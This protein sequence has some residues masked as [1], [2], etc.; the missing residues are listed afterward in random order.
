MN[1]KGMGYIL[2]DVPR[3]VIDLPKDEGMKNARVAQYLKDIV[4]KSRESR[5]VRLFAIKIIRERHVAPKDYMGEIEA[6]F[7]FVR[8]EI[9]YRKDAA[10]LDTFTEPEQ[11]IKDYL[12]GTPSGDCDDKALLL[13]S[14][15]L[16]LGHVP[17]FV[18][19][20]NMPGGKYTHIYV[21]VKHPKEN[22]WICAETT[23]NVELGWCPPTYK[24]GIITIINPKEQV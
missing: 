9:P 17:R 10:F 23:E 6:L 7:E 3:K 18:L 15:L 20:N 22:S 11:Q 5:V 1:K 14:M 19:T 21:E 13:A 4:L 2:G 16:A 12:F 24:R 8:D